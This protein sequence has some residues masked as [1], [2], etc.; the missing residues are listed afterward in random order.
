MGS[1]TYIGTFGVDRSYGLDTGDLDGDGDLDAVVAKGSGQPETVWLNDGSGDLTPHPTTPSFGGDDSFDIALGDLD[2]DGDLDAV[3]ANGLGQ[4]QTVWLNDGAGNFAAQS[5]TPDF[6]EGSSSCVVL[7]DLD[8]DG[9]LD[10]IIGDYGSADVTVWLNGDLYRVMLPL[11][12]R[13]M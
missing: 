13:D 3:V 5:D 12:L 6:G 10:T 1:L 8:G 9:D 7:G 11:V 4:A 2:G